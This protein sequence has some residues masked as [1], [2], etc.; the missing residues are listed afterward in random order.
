MK[1][2]S[3]FQSIPNSD[4]SQQSEELIEVYKQSWIKHGWN[5]I[6]LNEEYSKRNELFHKLDLGNP[7]ANFY[8][9]IS[10]SMWKYHRSCYCRLLAYCQYVRENGATLY[11]D[12]D[13]INYGFLPGILKTTQEDS[14]FCASRCMVYL[15]KKGADQIESA[16]LNFNNNEFQESEDRGSCNDMSIMIKYTNCF[17]FQKDQNNQNYVSSIMPDLSNQTSLVHYDGGCYRRGVDR[18]FSRL[19]IIKQYHKFSQQ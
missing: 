11:A 17:N 2:I 12:Y 13:V 3:Y 18:K 8:K 15:G 10:S 1:V 7:D 9:T 4:F 5:P 14:C 16:I 19:D 6:V